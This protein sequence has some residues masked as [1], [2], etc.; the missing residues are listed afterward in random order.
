MKESFHIDARLTQT[1]GQWVGGKCLNIYLDPES[2][3]RHIATIRT[4]NIDGTIEW[5]SGDPLQNPTLK[6]V[7]TTG[8]KTEGYRTLR[9]AFEPDANVPGGCDKDASSALNGSFTDVNIL[10]RSRVDLQVK[11]TWS[12]IGDNGLF[13]GDIVVG[14]VALLRDRLDLAVENEEIIFLRQYFDNGS[15]VTDGDNKSKTNEQGV[16]RFEWAFDG[17]SC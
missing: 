7:E 3:V 12:Y 11:Q 6:G 14:E 4:S 8:G 2:N 5:F 15:W 16:A 17:R 1:N 10:V 13:E 9:V